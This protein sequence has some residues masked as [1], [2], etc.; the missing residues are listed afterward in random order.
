MGR[1]SIGE[2]TANLAQRRFR[3]ADDGASGLGDGGRAY[4]RRQL[5][6]ALTE[7]RRSGEA[8]RVAPKRQQQGLA[9]ILTPAE[10]QLIRTV[11]TAGGYDLALTVRVRD[12]RA[13]LC[14]PPEFRALPSLSVAILLTCS[15]RTGAAFAK[16]THREQVC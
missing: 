5:L 4:C 1:G 13:P 8:P 11:R 12:G 9:M 10:R 16:G 7:A 3:C 14:S 15:D 2:A 6:A